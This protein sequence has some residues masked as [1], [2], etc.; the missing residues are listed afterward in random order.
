M[1][2]Q[3]P[4]FQER[5]KYKRTHELKTHTTILYSRKRQSLERRMGACRGSLETRVSFGWKVRSGGT[6]SDETGLWE[7]PDKRPFRTWSLFTSWGLFPAPSTPAFGHAEVLCFLSSSRA[8]LSGASPDHWLYLWSSFFQEVSP[9]P[10]PQATP[11]PCSLGLVHSFFG[12]RLKD[13]SLSS[14]A[15]RF[16]MERVLWLVLL[17][18]VSMRMVLSAFYYIFS[19]F[20]PI[21]QRD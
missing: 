5:I 16:R 4:S 9:S 11:N 19:F 3:D 7:V 12:P 10:N 20:P 8:L 13:P 15:T 2:R 17:W 18:S 21:L 6:G 1:F 14:P